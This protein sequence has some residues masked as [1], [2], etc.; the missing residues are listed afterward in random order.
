[1]SYENLTRKY[2]KHYPPAD[3]YLLKVKI[4]NTITRCKL[5]SM[6]TPCS[7]ASIIDFEQVIAG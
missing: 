2:L 3:I 6:L 1:M 4:R 5:C 7:S